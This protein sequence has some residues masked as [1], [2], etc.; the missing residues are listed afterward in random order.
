M[1]DLEY[2]CRLISCPGELVGIYQNHFSEPQFSHGKNHT[3]LTYSTVNIHECLYV[4]DSVVGPGDMAVN[5]V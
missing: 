1:K 5:K 4:P 3:S 2:R